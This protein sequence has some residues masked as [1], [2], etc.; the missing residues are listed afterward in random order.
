M[1][2]KLILDDASPLAPSIW[3]ASLPPEDLNVLGSPATRAGAI[4]VVLLP[5]LAP[6]ADSDGTLS[7]EP[8]QARVLNVGNTAQTVMIFG[9]EA[10]PERDED[11]IQSQKYGPRVQHDDEAF[12]KDLASLPA[13]LANV[14]RR[15]FETA[16]TEFGGYFQRTQI[17]RFVNRPN[18]FWTI[19]VQ[20]RDRSFRI[21]LR[22]TPERFRGVT[23]VAIRP[24]RNG[25]STLKLTRADQLDHVLRALRIAAAA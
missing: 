14:G 15:L 5:N 19:K 1:A 22:G 12:L 13:D 18:N 3:T 9:R 21:T 17:G 8:S 24:D 7:F 23:S 16:R 25:Y 2:I 20:P 10:A 6:P 4:S 11:E